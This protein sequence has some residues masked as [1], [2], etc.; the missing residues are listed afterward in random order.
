MGDGTEIDAFTAADN[1]KRATELLERARGTLVEATRRDR[2]EINLRA[3]SKRAGLHESTLYHWCG[4]QEV[5]RNGGQP[6]AAP[7]A[8]R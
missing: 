1:F 4:G 2:N 6:T 5:S 7:G 3:L 8:A